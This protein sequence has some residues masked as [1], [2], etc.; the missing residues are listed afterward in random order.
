MG[1]AGRH[2]SGAASCSSASQNSALA[3]SQAH[4]IAA[5]TSYLPYGAPAGGSVVGSAFGY[6]GYR[7][8]AETG[9]YHTAS[10]YYD[11]NRPVITGRLLGKRYA[12][13]SK[14]LVLADRGKCHSTHP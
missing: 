3:V 10:R 9:L 11:R 6:A 8:D 4:N 2:R 13:R 1:S 5:Q 14:P 7:Y 12:S